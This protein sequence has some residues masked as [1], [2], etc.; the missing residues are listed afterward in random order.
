MER[1][2]LDNL[3]DVVGLS[4]DD[5]AERTYAAA[6][7]LALSGD[8]AAAAPKLEQFIDK[9]PNS[10]RLLAARFHLGQCHFDN[11]N[12]DGALEAFEAV[13]AAL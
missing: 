9:Y 7:D 2:Q 13:I 3:P 4:E 10:I 8:C 1:G 6:Q 5:I 12:G 11:D